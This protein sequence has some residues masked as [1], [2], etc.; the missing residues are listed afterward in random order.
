MKCN[1]Y[2]FLYQRYAIQYYKFFKTT[3]LF[4]L[5]VFVRI[6]DSMINQDLICRLF[7]DDGK[8]ELQ[9]R[10]NRTA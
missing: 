6:S 5:K 10:I 9:H 3:L 4:T 8:E 7:Y 1:T 2:L